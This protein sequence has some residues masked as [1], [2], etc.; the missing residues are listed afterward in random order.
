MEWEELGTRKI[1]YFSMILLLEYLFSLK[2]L[3]KSFTCT[4]NYIAWPC[5]K[6]MG[7]MHS[8]RSEKYKII[9]YLYVSR[10][11][12]KYTTIQVLMKFNLEVQ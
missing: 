2:I 4:V 3:F 7:G 10:S 6:E 5:G 1:N 9:R 8:T 11:S 12:K